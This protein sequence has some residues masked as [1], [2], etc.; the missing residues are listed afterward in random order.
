LCARIFAYRSPTFFTRVSIVSIVKSGG[1]GR[2]C[3]SCHVSNARLGDGTTTTRTS[4]VLINLTNVVSVAAGAAHSLAMTGS[5]AIYSW[6]LGTSGQLGRGST[7]SVTTPTLIPNLHVSAM[8]AGD[9]FSAAIGA[10][11]ILLAWGVN[12]SGQI[13]DTSTTQRTSPTVVSGPPSVSSHSLG[14]STRWP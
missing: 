8:A 9:N 13:G 14:I 12:S 11:G 10:D 4:P 1:L 5:G 2:W 3:T 7:A 6:G